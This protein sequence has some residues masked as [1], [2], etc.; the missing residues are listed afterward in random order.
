M[1]ID[2]HE[3]RRAAAR[4]AIPL[5]YMFPT[6]ADG[7]PDRGVIDA[8]LPKVRDMLDVLEGGMQSGEIGGEPCG[9]TDAFLIPILFYA[10]TTSEGGVMIAERPR[11]NAY[12][13]RRL[14]RPSV[15]S[16][17]PAPLAGSA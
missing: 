14:S 6:T 13:D 5:A 11:L 10:R 3:F 9:R 8:L 4:P 16:T 1:D 17:L 7:K 15:Q 2:H 12:L